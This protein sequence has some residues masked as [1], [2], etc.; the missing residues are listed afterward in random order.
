MW[1]TIL[2][3]VLF[4]WKFLQHADMI[5]HNFVSTRRR[6]TMAS[7]ATVFLFSRDRLCGG[8][9]TVSSFFAE[10]AIHGDSGMRLFSTVIHFNTF[11]RKDYLVSR[12][13]AGTRDENDA[14][15]A[16]LGFYMNPVMRREPATFDLDLRSFGRPADARAR[17]HK[18]R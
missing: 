15:V 1:Y 17:G 12:A 9:V 2:I 4:M 8:V 11:Q 3:S 7:F 14:T 16:Y 13:S 18:M 5:N 6:L 10:T